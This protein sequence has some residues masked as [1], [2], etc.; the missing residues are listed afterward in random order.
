MDASQVGAKQPEAMALATKIFRRRRV[1]SRGAPGVGASDLDRIWAFGSEDSPVGAN[2]HAEAKPGRAQPEPHPPIEPDNQQALAPQE[3]PPVSESDEEDRQIAEDPAD[4]LASE[5]AP[6]TDEAARGITDEGTPSEASAGEPHDEVPEAEA[7]APAP[8][9]PSDGGKVSLSSATFE[10][11]RSLGL[12]VTQANRLLRY[13]DREPFRSADD[14][15][16][17][18]GF[19]KKLRAEL[20]Q[21]VTG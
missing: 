12:S 21:R 3:S 20:K 18:P 1:R 19:P 7:E 9:E 16:R 11:L 17:V 13:R 14:L 6:P 4:E 15:D 10:E 5:A 2:G 8:K